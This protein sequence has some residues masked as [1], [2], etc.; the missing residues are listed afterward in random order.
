MVG[1]VGKEQ[2]KLVVEGLE[3]RFQECSTEKNGTPIRSDIMQGLKN[4]YDEVKDDDIKGKA[5]Q[6][7]RTEEDPKYQKKSAKIWKNT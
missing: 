7:I 3:N 6:L 5:L 2:Q 4:L 1:V